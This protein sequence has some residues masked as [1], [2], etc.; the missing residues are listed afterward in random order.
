MIKQKKIKIK[1]D[2]TMLV[3]REKYPTFTNLFDEFF[4]LYNS[5]NNS[6]SNQWRIPSANI[7]ESDDKYRIELETPGFKKEDF[8]ISL[9][10]E[11]LT[12][13]SKEES[14]KE[15]STDKYTLKEFSTS[16]F[17]RCFRIPEDTDPEKIDAR[18]ENGILYLDL[19][20]K[21]EVSKKTTREIQIS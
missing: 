17:S 7:K 10:D 13:K 1:E 9:D 8:E 18:Y 11:L 6:I 21:T 2:K 14:T 20:K 15:V 19:A 12:I 3:R 5:E 4:N 16:R